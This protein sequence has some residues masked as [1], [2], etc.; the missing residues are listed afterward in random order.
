[1]KKAYLTI[2]ALLILAIIFVFVR[3]QQALNSSIAKI[4]ELEAEE[5][6]DYSS[7]ESSAT[8]KISTTQQGDELLQN[9]TTA[10]Q[11]PAQDV[12]CVNDLIVALNNSVKDIDTRFLATNEDI[13]KQLLGENKFKEKIISPNPKLINA[14]G[15]M[16]DRWGT[17]Y[18]FHPLTQKRIAIR[19]AG[20]DKEMF[21]KD[22][23]HRNPDGSFLSPEEATDPSLPND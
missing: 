11:T 3:N 9:Y 20:P 1:M 4:E 21:T 16:I 6:S 18:L 14:T 19:S 12:N 2:S 8:A 10:Q 17:P 7:E 15:Q 22:D 13:T 23:L 5:H